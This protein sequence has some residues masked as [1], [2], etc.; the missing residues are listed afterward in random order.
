LI[1]ILHHLFILDI[2]IDTINFINHL[3]LNFMKNYL[4]VIVAVAGL[5][6][7][8][9]GS[10]EK[11]S[12]SAAAGGTCVG[13]ETRKCLTTPGGDVAWGYYNTEIKVE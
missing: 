12:A 4:K 2:I 10:I 3:N 6:A 5:T 13:D 9:F 1:L 11:A 7:A 8:M